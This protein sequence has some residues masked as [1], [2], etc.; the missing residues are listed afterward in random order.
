MQVYPVVIY[1]DPD[2]DYGTLVPDLPGCHSAGATIAEALEET[3]E[4]IYAHLEGM[5]KDREIFPRPT[6]LSAIAARPSGGSNMPLI[7]EPQRLRPRVADR[8][9]RCGCCRA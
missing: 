2:S 8:I 6:D 9:A 1:K 4:A 7:S 5:A 3:K